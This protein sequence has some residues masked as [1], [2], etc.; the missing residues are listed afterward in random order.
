[1]RATALPLI[2]LLAATA[3]AGCFSDDSGPS[4]LDG[5]G[6]AVDGGANNTTALADEEVYIVGTDLSF[7]PESWYKVRPA[8]VEVSAGDIVNLT[9]KNALGNQYEHSLVLEG[10]DIKLGPIPEGEAEATIFTADQTGT[11]AF[12]CDVGNHRDLGMEGTFTVTG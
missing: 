7:Y 6:A 10:Y 4:G 5:E 2:A 1:M 8:T 11:F 12:Y 3:L 9:F